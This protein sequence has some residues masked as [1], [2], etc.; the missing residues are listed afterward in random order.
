MDA[1]LTANHNHR[2]FT[3]VFSLRHQWVLWQSRMI[4]GWLWTPTWGTSQDICLWEI[5]L[6]VVFCLTACWTW[7]S[8][9]EKCDHTGACGVPCGT[10]DVKQQEKSWQTCRG[11]GDHQLHGSE[12]K[13]YA[14]AVLVHWLASCWSRRDSTWWPSTLIMES[15]FWSFLSQFPHH[16]DP[17]G[18][19]PVIPKHSYDMVWSEW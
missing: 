4:V 16:I 11:E 1:P 2:Q 5:L 19:L 6:L 8:G 12:A 18:C 3:V 15:V 9:S 7:E 13:H 17:R 10:L 14:L